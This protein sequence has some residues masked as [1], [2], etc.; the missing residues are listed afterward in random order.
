MTRSFTLQLFTIVEPASSPRPLTE[1][2]R[3]TTSS[4]SSSFDSPLFPRPSFFVSSVLSHL[5]ELQVRAACAHPHL[6]APLY[7]LHPESLSVSYV[8]EKAAPQ[9]A[10]HQIL[11][12]FS[13]Y[14]VFNPI[15]F[16][17]RRLARHWAGFL[18]QIAEQKNK[19]RNETKKRRVSDRLEFQPT[20]V[21][22][23]EEAAT[24]LRRIRTRNCSLGRSPRPKSQIEIQLTLQIPELASHAALR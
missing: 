12:F 6:C 22:S 3:L 9:A 18:F 13:S 20:V 8:L 7:F 4:S 10:P 5:A 1:E 21:E 16:I 19:K 2:A 24:F 15:Q 23:I 17:D 11:F 14:P